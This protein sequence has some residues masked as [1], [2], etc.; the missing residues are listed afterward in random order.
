[1]IV[2]ISNSSSESG[3]PSLTGCTWLFNRLLSWSYCYAGKSPSQPYPS[4]LNL[5]LH[6]RPVKGTLR[7]L[8]EKILISL[9]VPNILYRLSLIVANRSLASRLS[10]PI[11]SCFQNSI[12][13]L[14]KT[15]RNQ[16]QPEKRNIV[17]K[18]TKSRITRKVIKLLCSL[19]KKW[20]WTEAI[21]THM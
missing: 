13:V 4:S 14:P 2:I 9:C 17:R 20:C 3:R 6:S 18:R 21:V 19:N 16:F 8:G 5:K 12:W 1:M 10:L 7:K 11:P 15:A